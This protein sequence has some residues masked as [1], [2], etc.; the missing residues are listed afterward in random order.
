VLIS[1]RT[2]VHRLLATTA[3]VVA[4]ATA[5]CRAELPYRWRHPGLGFEMHSDFELVR[6]EYVF[7]AELRARIEALQALFEPASLAGLHVY[8]HDEATAQLGGMTVSGWHGGGEVHVMAGYGDDLQSPMPMMSSRETFLHELVHALVQRAGLELPRWYEE[9]LCEVLSASMLDEQGQ[10]IW[11]PNVE[12]ER[13][14]RRL[15]GREAWLDG[16]QLLSFD[17]H[18]PDDAGRAAAL[19]AQGTSFTWFLLRDALPSNAASIAAVPALPRERLLRRFDAWQA[20]IASGTLSDL[21]LPLSSHPVAAV[22]DYAASGLDQDPG[23]PAWW[24]A[25]ERLLD[26]PE[27]WVRATMRL[28]VLSQPNDSDAASLRYADWSTSDRRQLRLAGWL[29]LA[30]L[31]GVQAAQRF[32]R[33]LR[34][35]DHEWAQPLLWLLM[36]V[37]AQDGSR[38]ALDAAMLSDAD[39]MVRVARELADDVEAMAAT[40]RF[41]E[42]A[43]RYLR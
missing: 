11:L 42:R 1:N 19:Y 15:R 23:N 25:A 7:D 39:A 28:R 30:Q 43:G 41:D 2:R 18:Y 21:M 22:R 40:L 3:A 36:I 9:G 17:D 10:L 35:E 27:R 24:D 14:A 4:M 37:P 6:T 32:A 34:V 33:E 31:G 13:I 5:G 16:E 20:Q 26:D 29:A 38:R 12:R 8:V